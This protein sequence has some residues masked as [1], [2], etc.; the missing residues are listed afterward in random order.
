VSEWSAFVVGACLA[1]LGFC[2]LYWDWR[3][4]FDEDIPDE[5]RRRLRERV[6]PGGPG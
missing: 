1:T 6:G 5:G 2:I 4:R 3:D